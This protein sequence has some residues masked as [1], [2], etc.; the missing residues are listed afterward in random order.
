MGPL[1]QAADLITPMAIRVA[2]TLR[3]ADHIADGAD[4]DGELAARTGADPQTLRRLM[5]H[6]VAAGVFGRLSSGR[7]TLRDLGHELLGQVREWLDIN[8]AVGRADLGFVA[9]LHTVQSGKPG[10]PELYEIGYWE[11]L[12]RNPVLSAS[13]DRLMSSDPPARDIIEKFDW[14]TVCRVTDVGGGK[15]T[16]L[17]EL[18]TAYPNLTGTLVERP[19]PAAAA[20]DTLSAAGLLD[21]CQIVEGSF[22]DA[23]PSGA[24]VYVLSRVLND[25]DDTHAVAILQRCADAAR[26]SGRILIVEEGNISDP[27]ENAVGTEMDLRMLV[28]CGGAERTLSD[29]TRLAEAA[30]VVVTSAY[31]GST[32]GLVVLVPTNAT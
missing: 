26:P 6:L 31:R 25:W 5:R 24:D 12:D 8:G 21:R 27:D 29:L 16:L 7:Y 11:D 9:L 19:G 30:G 17:A 22:F 4:S 18:L 23:L 1:W 2:A 13:L 32:S 3:I 10:Y 14:S 20:F 28:Y 15:G